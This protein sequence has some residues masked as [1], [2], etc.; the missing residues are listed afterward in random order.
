MKLFEYGKIGDLQVKNRIVM[1]P[2]GAPADI[3]GG[4]SK[5][6]ID[7]YERRAKG[8][9]GLIITGGTVVS[10]KF[11]PRQ[12]AMHNSF[13]H[14][15]RLGELADKVHAYNCALCLQLSPGMGRLNFID[16]AI[17]PLSASEVPCASFPELTCKPFTIEQIKE[18]VKAMGQSSLLAKKAGV[19]MIEIHAYGGYL[20]DQFMSPFWNKRDDQYGGSLENRLRFLLEIID[21]IRLLCGPRFPIAVKYTLDSL[22]ENDRHLEEGL[23]ISEILDNSPIDLLH[24]ARG[25]YSC[26]YRMVGSVY[27]PHG[28]DIDILEKIKKVV[29]KHPV[30]VHGKLNHPEL[31]E[32]VLSDGLADYIAIGRGL[33]A[34]PDWPLKAKKH[35]FKNINPCIGCG[36]CHYNT[37]NGRMISC[38]VNPLTGHEKDFELSKGEKILK[39]LIIGAGPAGMKAAI[40]AAERGFDV[41]I[42]EK[43]HYLGG[44]L[45]AAG[46]P[47]LKQDVRDQVSFLRQMIYDQN[48]NVVLGKEATLS[49][50]KKINPDVVIVATGASPL[51][52][53][54]PG[55]EKK[56]VVSAEDVLLK[57][58]NVGDNIVIVGGGLVGCETA[59]ELS[60]QGKHITI[61]E[62]QDDILKTTSHFVAN[63]QNIRQLV[64]DNKVKLELNAKL[65]K[66]LDDRIEVESIGENKEIFCDNVVF[67]IGY[68]SNHDLLEEIQQAGFNVTNIGDNVKPGKVMN[69]IHQGYHV[70][71]TL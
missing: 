28:F 11:E 48:V 55:Y 32:S 19:D 53:K 1:A 21:E 50:V 17:P 15:N 45:C 68:Y 26:R 67:A 2:M 43:N 64:S 46:A 5:H 60:M 25:S 63:D 51:I 39:V 70:I 69:A 58:V 33:L 35:K 36:E 49:D 42:M 54:V 71:R 57:K 12:G 22:T 66:I 56:H 41:T 40:T 52:L 65:S 8:G 44:L 10:E 24:V 61:V 59:I 47:Q 23:R 7:F 18:L 20:L 62:L 3:D 37:H 4:F 31:A 38:A 16:P 27:Q 29:K 13:F 9:V 14:N 30:I 34:E 6:M